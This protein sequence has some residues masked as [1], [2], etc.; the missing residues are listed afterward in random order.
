MESCHAIL[1]LLVGFIVI[2]TSACHANGGGSAF[3]GGLFGGMVGSAITA[4]R[5]DVVVVDRS[6]PQPAPR[7]DYDY[8]DELR[9]ANRDLK[10]KV[11]Q[12][13]RQVQQLQDELDQCHQ[14][15]RKVRKTSYKKPIKPLEE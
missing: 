15:L 12:L 8:C 1:K 9:E 2:T 5:R 13:K 11:R 10:Q 3:A 14:Q 7:Y 4:P 6:T